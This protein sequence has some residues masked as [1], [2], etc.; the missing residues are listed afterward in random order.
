MTA[1]ENPTVSWE[2]NYSFNA[3]IRAGASSITDLTLGFDWYTRKT[4]DLL[5]NRPLAFSLGFD[6]VNDNI[7][8]L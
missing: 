8:D 3:G 6:G 2:K 5:L 1:V 7:S 4:S